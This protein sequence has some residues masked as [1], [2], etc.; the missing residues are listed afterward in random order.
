GDF[1]GGGAGLADLLELLDRG[2]DRLVDAALE[3]HRV[4]ARGDVLHALGHDGLREHGRGRGAVAGHVGSL[5]G[6]FLHELRAHVL[7]LVLELD[8]L[9][10]RDTVLGDGGGAER[11]LEDDVAALRA[12]RD[13]DRIGQ[14]VDARDHANARVLFE[15]DVFGCHGRFLSMFVIPADQFTTAMMSSSRITRSSSPSTFTAVPEYLPKSTLSPTLRSTGVS[16]PS[17]LRLPGPMASTSP[18]SGFSAAVS[19]MTIPDAVLR[20]SSRRLMITRSCS[21]RSFIAVAPDWT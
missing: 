17:S 11:A 6:D 8:L 12:Q 5:G 16:L 14:D 4:H 9:R 13:L 20:S 15:F 7:E 10:D 18:W 3:V 21:G 2:G 1:L 19:G